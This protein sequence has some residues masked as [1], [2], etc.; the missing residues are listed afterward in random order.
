MLQNL[1]QRKEE[2]SCSDNDL[3]HQKL[4]MEFQKIIWKLKQGFGVLLLLSFVGASVKHS[5]SIWGKIVSGRI[6]WSL[7]LQNAVCLTF[8]QET[9]CYQSLRGKS[10]F[11][12]RCSLGKRPRGRYFREKRFR[13]WVPTKAEVP[14]CPMANI[15]SALSL[16][17]IPVLSPCL[18][19]WSL[20]PL[21]SVSFPLN[22]V[23]LNPRKRL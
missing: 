14:Q 3:L 12:Q 21:I 20:V 22:H 5:T 11:C 16:P 6:R 19:D 17:F 8:W 23:S 9:L 15:L 2:V 7:F 10:F 13:G 1:I 4:Q 18:L